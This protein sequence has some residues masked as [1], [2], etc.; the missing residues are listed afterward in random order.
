MNLKEA[1]LFLPIITAWVEGKT[2]QFNS[3][4]EWTDLKSD[5]DIGFDRT[6]DRYRI[7]PEPQILYK[8]V[9][10]SSSSWFYENTFADAQFR[11]ND[12]LKGNGYVITFKEVQE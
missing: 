9:S 2:I 6:P 7:K 10:Y 3:G 5:G 1:K 8:V 12:T 11:L 4:N